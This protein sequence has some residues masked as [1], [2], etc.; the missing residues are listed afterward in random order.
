MIQKHVDLIAIALLLTAISFYVHARNACA[1]GLRSSHMVALTQ[2]YQAPHVS[3]PAM[4]HVPF[5]RD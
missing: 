5:A 3:L 2:H 4:P 1:L